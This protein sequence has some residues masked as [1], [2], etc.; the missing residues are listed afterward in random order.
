ML[1]KEYINSDK[2]TTMITNYS[3]SIRILNCLYFF[4]VTLK[5]HFN[6]RADVFSVS[7]IGCR[8]RISLMAAGKYRTGASS[9]FSIGR[10]SVTVDNAR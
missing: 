6:C 4:N 9:V 7:Q 3:C 8:S 1:V 5:T 2:M 10:V